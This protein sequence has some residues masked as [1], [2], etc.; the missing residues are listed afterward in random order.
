MEDQ[1]TVK[2]QKHAKLARPALGT[3]ARHEIALIGTPCGVI[4]SLCRQLVEQLGS[5]LKVAYVD[6][7]H[8]GAEEGADDQQASPAKASLVYTDKIHFHR[9][10]QRTNADPFKYRQ[11]FNEQDVVLVNGNHFT[12][13]RQLVCI[14]PRKF[15]SLRR[16]LDRLTEVAGFIQVAP[17]TELPDFLKEHIP[18]WKDLPNWPLTDTAAIGHFISNS[19]QKEIP[20]V[21][22]LVLAGGK[23]TRMGRDKGRLDYHGLP[24]REYLYQLMEKQLKIPAFLSC[25][26]EQVEQMPAD[27]RL[28]TDSFFGLGPYGAILSAFREDPDSA[29]LVIA[30]DLPFV[31]ESGLRELLAQR[32]PSAVATAFHNPAT[33]FPD[34]LLTL[35]EPRAYSTLLQFMAQ[36]YSCP[37]KVLINT[38]ANIIEVPNENLLTNVN[39]PTEWEKAQTLL[40]QIS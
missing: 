29:W 4:Q 30:C 34:P 36:G 39:N 12:A 21:K 11:W 10:D 35:W 24:Q 26:S 1:S 25:R 37:R 15:D 18:N 28:I 32:N 9:L 20:P 16:K 33:N 22:G 6:A 40:A 19:Y 38:A 27:H 23:S 31:D 2:H 7:D 5:N 8:Q 14:D 3:F 17:E 13:K